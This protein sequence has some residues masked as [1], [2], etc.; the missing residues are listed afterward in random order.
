MGQRAFVKNRNFESPLGN[1]SIFHNFYDDPVGASFSEED[2][3]TTYTHEI[4]SCDSGIDVFEKYNASE[5]QPSTKQIYIFIEKEDA[6]KSNFFGTACRVKMGE[7]RRTLMR[8]LLNGKVNISI[9]DSEDST[10]NLTKWAK[11]VLDLHKEKT[12]KINPKV[13]ESAVQLELAEASELNSIFQSIFS[14]NDKFAD[15]LKSGVSAMEEW[16]FT[17]ENYEYAKYKEKLKPLIPVNVFSKDADYWATGNTNSYTIAANGAKQ[18]IQLADNLD[19]IVFNVA[20][21]ITKATPNVGD[22]MLLGPILWVKTLLEDKLFPKL[23]AILSKIK[24]I[25]N[26]AVTFI[27]DI[28]TKELDKSLALINAF[29]CGLING[30][31]S[32][33][34]AIISII[35]FLVDNISILELERL[36]ATEISKYQEKLE[37]IEDIVDVVSGKTSEIFQGLKTTLATFGEESLKFIKEITKKISGLSQYFWAFFIGGVLLELIIDAILAYFTGGTSLAASIS[38]KITRL[39]TKANQLTNK[40]IRVSQKL[41]K[42]VANSSTELLQWLKQEFQELVEALKSGKLIEYIR[43][44]LDELFGIEIKPSQTNLLENWDNIVVS[45]RGRRFGQRLTKSNLKLL[46]KWLKRKGVD[47]ELHPA[48]GSYTIEGFFLNGNPVK[49]PKGAAALFITNGKKMKI[50]L[51]EGATV[52]EFFHEFMHFRHAKKVGLKKYLALGGKDTLGELAKEQLVFEKLI[53]YRKYLTKKELKHA[54]WY[55]ND[56]IRYKFGEDPLSFDFDIKKIPNVRREVRMSEL[57]N[58]K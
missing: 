16:K 44:K 7:E 53:E 15:W 49:M 25:V 9:N 52:Y 22:D 34:Q 31:I 47:L 1:N 30:L 17:E 50:I 2:E 13:L 38:A 48:N 24:N 42:K 36:T 46:K 28:V 37:F 32:L 35:A 41:G 55:I 43:R 33:L 29:L 12:G 27:N 20:H 56:K 6:K 3:K 5:Y 54:L 14:V 39:S 10:N 11:E 40:G 18:L 57:I 8:K 19:E 58:K 26:E 4:F 23:T 21:T 45:G 51:R